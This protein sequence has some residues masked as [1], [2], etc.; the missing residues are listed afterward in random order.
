M[1]KR[2]SEGLISAEQPRSALGSNNENVQAATLPPAPVVEVVPVI[3]H[4]LSSSSC[5]R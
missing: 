2:T 3:Q 4:Q 1:I 5:A